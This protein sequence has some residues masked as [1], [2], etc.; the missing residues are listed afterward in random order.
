MD[1]LHLRNHDLSGL[2]FPG[3]TPAPHPH[4]VLQEQLAYDTDI[5]R[6]LAEAPGALA[7]G[8]SMML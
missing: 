5:D 2:V 1:L 7:K 8:E 6:R 4:G 3:L